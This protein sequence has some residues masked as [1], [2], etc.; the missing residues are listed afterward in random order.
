[1]FSFSP[2]AGCSIHLNFCFVV[3]VLQKWHSDT[4]NKM[5][6]SFIKIYKDELIEIQLQSLLN[7]FSKC[8][9]QSHKA[10]FLAAN[11]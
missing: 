3:N 1:M 8:H 9:G 4:E 5:N 6:K 2:V 10:N 7:Q 11:Y